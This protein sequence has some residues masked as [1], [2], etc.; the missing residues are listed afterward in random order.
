MSDTVVPQF[1]NPEVA[2]DKSEWGFMWILYF[3]TPLLNIGAGVMNQLMQASWVTAEKQN[4]MLWE[5][6]VGGA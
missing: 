5:V 1:E 4:V 2:P 3:L 6:S